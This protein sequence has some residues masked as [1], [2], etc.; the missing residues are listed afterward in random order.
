MCNAL[1]YKKLMTGLEKIKQ[2]RTRILEITAKYG[3]GDVRAF[4]SV[5]RGEDL[6]DSDIDFLVEMAPGRD[7]FDVIALSRELEEL[8]RQK[9]D[10]VSGD[11]LSPYLRD[12]VLSEAVAI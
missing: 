11:E 5:A 1:A 4:G 2:N 6:P 12:R 9:T 7:L 8:L 10:V 3:A